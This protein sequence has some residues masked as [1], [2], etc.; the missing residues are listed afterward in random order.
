[1]R[2]RTAIVLGLG[3]LFVG[4]SAFGISREA[5]RPIAARDF[6]PLKSAFVDLHSL[7]SQRYQLAGNPGFPIVTDSRRPVGGAA[8]AEL[9]VLMFREMLYSVAYANDTGF[10]L[11]R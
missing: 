8:V 1:M 10:A 7:N 2:A 11:P 9:G 3:A 6:R 5:W 4:V